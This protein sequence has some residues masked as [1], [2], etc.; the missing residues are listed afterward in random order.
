MD[1]E[2]HRIAAQMAAEQKKIPRVGSID[3]TE[4]IKALE[5]AADAELGIEDLH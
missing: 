3:V 1:A 5:A 4:K 2:A